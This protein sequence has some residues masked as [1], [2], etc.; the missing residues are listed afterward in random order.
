V[1]PIQERLG[2]ALCAKQGA[3]TVAVLLYGAP[4][5]TWNA[6]D[7]GQAV[8]APAAELLGRHGHEAEP[9]AAVAGEAEPPASPVA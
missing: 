6:V 1:L 3:R 9:V 7:L 2:G 8:Q 5:A 4:C